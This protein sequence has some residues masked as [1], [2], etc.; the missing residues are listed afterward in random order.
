MKTTAT[1]LCIACLSAA[2]GNVSADV[3]MPSIFGDNMVLQRGTALPIWGWAE[4]GEKI[5]V[6]I[7]KQ[8]ATATADQSG[9]WMVK[10]KPLSAGGP[11]EL[12]V[13]GRNRLVFRNVMVGEV[14]ICSGQ[15]NMEWPVAASLNG[16]Q[17]QAA[18]N[19]PLIRLFTVKHKVSTTPQ[20]DPEG[21]W[22]VCSPQTVGGF[23]GVGYFF[24]REIHKR[25]GVPVGLIQSAWGGTPAEAWTSKSVLEADPELKP[26]VERWDQ[27]LAQYPTA[28]ERYKQQLAD[29]E[30]SAAQAREKGE[31]EPKKPNPPEDPKTNPWLPAGLY[32]GMICPLIPFAIRGVIWYQGES[33][34]DRAYQYRRLFPA[35]IKCWRKAWGK[36]FPFLFV[37]LAN[38]ME[39]KPEPV[40][41]A[42]AELREAQ[43]M[44]LSLPKTGMAV[45]IDIGEANDI[46]PKNKQDVGLR[47]AL[48]A[49]K[50]AYG[51]NLV[52]SGPIYKSMKVEG[53]KIRLW[54]DNV[55]SGLVAKG[56]GVLKGFAIAGEDR[57]FVWAEAKIEGNTVVVWSEKVPKPV[58]V[59]YGW[60][61]NPVCNLYNAEGLPASPFRTDDWPG[62]TFGKK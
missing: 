16:S 30:K 36:E 13:S 3:R 38:F 37:Q 15:S 7:A 32:N 61:C 18:A 56:D 41:D 29:W 43:L 40:D 50:V 17:E 35:M 57:K 31:P 20:Q 27:A 9:R 49:M 44:T 47:L 48:A 19:Y 4:P 14:W 11:H 46:H 51:R 26:I 45:A 21:K 62:I 33:N 10:L 60:S 55:G 39:A 42:W 52:H 54:F 34:A 59:R 8:S 2:A 23:S 22:D 1:V 25:L 5:T 12:I 6:E 28:V 53:N 58:A 24:G